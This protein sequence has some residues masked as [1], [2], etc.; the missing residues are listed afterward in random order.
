MPYRCLN[1]ARPLAGHGKES[2]PTRQTRPD[3]GKSLSP[4][5]PDRARHRHICPP[6]R[7]RLPKMHFYQVG[8]IPIIR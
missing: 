8:V 5:G 2:E 6:R 7:A 4:R 3:G 1:V